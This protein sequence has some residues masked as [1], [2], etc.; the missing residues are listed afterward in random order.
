MPV[1]DTE[2]GTKL[3]PDCAEEVKEA[4]RVCRFCGYRFAPPSAAEGSLDPEADQSGAGTAGASTSSS[5]RKRKRRPVA[6][7]RPVVPPRIEHSDQERALIERNARQAAEESGLNYERALAIELGEF[8]NL[9]A[10]RY[11]AARPPRGRTGLRLLVARTFAVLLCAVAGVIV[12]AAVLAGV[13]AI[14]LVYA[15]LIEL[16]NEDAGS[17]SGVLAGQ[18]TGG[19]IGIGIVY[20][21]VRGG[22]LLFQFSIDVL[23]DR[24]G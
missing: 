11:A 23:W 10:E 6:P 13:R 2:E 18:V 19:L 16:N 7:P 1:M 4:A 24:D 8:R 15:S 17:D 12:I 5:P 3:C 20:L 14:I 21:I 22:I 9:G